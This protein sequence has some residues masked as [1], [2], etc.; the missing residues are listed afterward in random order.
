[1]L[2][3]SNQGSRCTGAGF[4]A[5]ALEVLA[6]S[7]GGLR[8]ET[9]PSIPPSTVFPVRFVHSV[10]SSKAHAGDEVVARTMQEVILPSGVRLPKGTM[11]LGHVTE[12]RPNRKPILNN[13]APG[14][15]LLGVHF[16]TVSG[17][18]ETI[19][20]NVAVRALAGSKESN[21]A[22]R[23]H[24]R[25]DTDPF[26]FMPPYSWGEYAPDGLGTMKLVGGGEFSP[27]DKVIRNEAGDLIGYNRKD[28]VFARLSAS[29]DPTSSANHRCDATTTEQS[30]A[31]FAP[32]ACGLYGLRDVSMADAG[33]TGSGVFTLTSKQRAVKL[34]AGATALLQETQSR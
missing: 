28:G 14:S 4:M 5:L 26:G 27:A 12:A 7:A 23:T 25:D 15:S 13:G 24:H 17:G 10:D 21:D 29:N 9:G 3:Q 31:I 32:T 6:L 19:P 11:L 18:T 30:V 8:A 33:T 2:M 20:V 16:D 1:M 22:E 34:D